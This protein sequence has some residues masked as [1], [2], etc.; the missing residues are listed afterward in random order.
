MAKS[1]CKD[2]ASLPHVEGDHSLDASDVQELRVQVQRRQGLIYPEQ[3]PRFRDLERLA[4]Q[5]KLT[6]AILAEAARIF[7]QFRQPGPLGREWAKAEL[8]A[9][10]A[11]SSAGA[12]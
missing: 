9:D 8:L 5:G 7:S 11:L 4:L 6:A 3:E 1:I 2:Y 10:L 12:S